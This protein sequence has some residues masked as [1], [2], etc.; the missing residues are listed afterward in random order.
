MIATALYDHTPSQPNEL[1]IHE[2]ETCLVLDLEDSSE[3]CHVRLLSSV[4][5]RSQ[6]E[7]YVPRSYL[8]LKPL[9]KPTTTTTTMTL[10]INPV[11]TLNTTQSTTTAS[12]VLL[13]KEEDLQEPPTQP[14]LKRVELKDDFENQ[15]PLP[16]QKEVTESEGLKLQQ[17]QELKWKLSQKLKKEGNENRVHHFEGEIPRPFHSRLQDVEQEK[18]SHHPIDVRSPELVPQ[19]PP[20]PPPLPTRSTP[21]TPT[22]SP[23]A[24]PSLA[25]KPSS[26][27]SL[28]PPSSLPRPLDNTYSSSLPYTPTPTPKTPATSTSN[29]LMPASPS[30]VGSSSSSSSLSPS[31]SPSGILPPPSSSSALPV[32]PLTTTPKPKPE[33]LEKPDPSL[34]RTWLD[35]SGQHRTEAAFIDSKEDKVRLHKTNGIKIEVPLTALSKE[36][37]WYVLT[38]LGRAV[39]VY[40]GFDWWAFLHTTCGI[41]EVDAK[42]YATQLVHE[43][44]DASVFTQLNREILKSIGMKEGDILRVL[45]HVPS[46]SSSPSPPTGSREGGGGLSSLGKSSS[47]PSTTTT[48]STTTA[49]TSSLTTPLLPPTGGATHDV[50]TGST[51]S[52]LMKE[53]LDRI[54][55]YFQERLQLQE[56]EKQVRDDEA[57]ARQLQLQLQLQESTTQHPPPP[58]PS[59]PLPQP[60]LLP[61]T[62]P[63]PVSRPNLSQST[64]VAGT[65]RALAP[66]PSSSSSSS[67]SSFL[68][69][70]EKRVLPLAPA[71]TGAQATPLVPMPA[72]APPLV[73]IPAQAQAQ[74]Q[75][76]PS[77]FVNLPSR[78]PLIPTPLVATLQQHGPPPTFIP[79]HTSNT[80]A[81]NHPHPTTFVSTYL[82]D[83]KSRNGPPHF[84]DSSSSGS[85]YWSWRPDPT[86]PKEPSTLLR[87]HA[88]SRPPRSGMDSHTP[89]RPSS[90]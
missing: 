57:L 65:V 58:P 45:K 49:A 17:Q 29:T 1:D 54:D 44:L 22:T 8:T 32:L 41:G 42:V 84:L 37:Q 15:L 79:T 19:L 82:L 63:I 83:S 26:S 64:S 5:A 31:P 46:S 69:T 13:N 74:A 87:L 48:T 7:G 43:K 18:L 9:P 10:F 56:K 28:V 23:P 40:N 36:D 89:T 76:F 38:L 24:L 33:G 53:N 60:S 21:I 77:S 72:Q 62:P 85:T 16:K 75:A 3:W 59:N 12:S 20:R 51:Q 25:S 68:A 90:V 61:P 27:A 34:V 30:K 39:V 50:M 78:T 88:R 47:P 52:H 66:T 14:Q 70:P 80:Y 2:G 11:N 86:T 6:K 4:K 55:H 71:P 35:F 67:S 81:P 73:P